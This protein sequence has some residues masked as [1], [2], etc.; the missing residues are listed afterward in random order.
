[1]KKTQDM[2]TSPTLLLGGLAAIV[3]A[4][5]LGL[6][7]GLRFGAS[8]AAQPTQPPPADA[9]AATTP[10]ADRLGDDGEAAPDGIAPATGDLS[11]EDV[12]RALIAGEDPFALPGDAAPAAAVHEQTYVAVVSTVEQNAFVAWVRSPADPDLGIAVRVS[13][14]AGGTVIARVPAEP[15]EGGE[16]DAN[17]QLGAPPPGVDEPYREKSILLS[18]LRKDD[19]IEIA[20]ST[21][22]EAGTREAVASRVVWIAHIEGVEDGRTVVSTEDR[23]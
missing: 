8:K 13:L 15:P 10:D 1:M 3:F 19:L 22:I 20:S 17:G 4:G 18:Q 21:V 5:M 23:F 11:D 14:S 9:P 6:G 7:L 12:L 2:R 16:P